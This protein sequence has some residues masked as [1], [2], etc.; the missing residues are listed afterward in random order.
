MTRSA[1]A[2][3]RESGIDWIGTIPGDWDVAPL[4]ARC[5]EVRRRNVG[6]RQSRI[7]S[8]SY[9]KIVRRDVESNF[10]LL[11]ESFE[12]YAVIEPGDVVLRLTDLQNDK[13]SLRV[14]LAPEAGAITSAYVS[15]RPARGFE[16]SFLF[17]LLHAYDVTKVFYGFG[18]GVRQSMKFDDLKRLPLVLP[19]LPNQR[20]VAAFLDNKTAAIDDL[21]AKK[22]RLIELLQEKRQ[23]LITQA[24]TKGL[25]PNVPMRDSRIEW[26]GDIPAHWIVA[27]LK[28]I[29]RGIEQGWSPECMNR[30]ADPG[31]WG[32][33]K[34]GC[35]NRGAFDENENKALPSD[36]R[37]R[38][39]LEI[40]A[41]NLLMSRASGSPDLIGSVALIPQCRERL[42]LSD[43]LYRLQPKG[44]RVVPGYLS[45]LLGSRAGRVQIES[46]IRGAEGLANNISQSDVKTVL[47]PIPP[48][49]EQTQIA[50]FLRQKCEV[51]GRTVGA[52]A[53]T[54]ARFREYR[55]SLISAAVT[56]KIEIPAEEAA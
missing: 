30:P 32:V 39:A 28:R 12:T 4:F 41:G 51:I 5:H 50:S 55:Q 38:P 27:P 26:L 49:E 37:P 56:G 36:L 44:E 35:V 9:G 18:G 11:P 22:E 40:R 7:L 53:S 43:K 45:L 13:T 15:L 23:A 29:L 24:V 6:N 34:A 48:M 8:L 21:V 10:G 46:F 33:L 17:Y 25:D 20:A 16:P 47:L 2:S 31:E 19:P 14:G 42:L 1:R 3:M 54:V 52:T